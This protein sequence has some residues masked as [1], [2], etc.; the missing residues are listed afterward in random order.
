MLPWLHVPN[1]WV[2][3]VISWHICEKEKKRKKWTMTTSSQMHSEI[4]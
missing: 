4:F 2:V 3:S 1:A